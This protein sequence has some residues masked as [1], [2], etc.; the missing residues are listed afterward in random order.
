MK[1]KILSIEEQHNRMMNTPIPKL[2]LSLALPTTISQLITVIYNTADTYF[3]S[4]IGTSAAAAT[5]VVFSLMSIIQALGFGVA[6]G[7][8]SIISRKLGAKENDKANICA[9]SAFSIAVIIGLIIMIIGLLTIKK[10]M[11]LLG[12]TETILPYACDYAKY[13]LISA[14]IMC[15]SFVLNNLLRA[16]GEAVLSMWGLCTGGILNMILDPLLIFGLNMGIAGAAIATALSQCVSFVI[17]LSPFLKGKSIVKLDLRLSSRK[18][19]MYYIIIKNGFPTICRQGMASVASA[20]MNI[21]AGAYGDAVLAAITISNKV[22]LLMRNMVIGIGQGMQPVVG[23]NYGAGNKTR[24]KKAFVFT[25]IIGTLVCTIGTVIIAI[26]AQD[27][28]A[29]FR[30]DPQVIEIGTK[31]LHYGCIVMPVLA[32][33]TYVNQMFQFLGFST[34]AIFLALCRQGIFF[35]PLLMILPPILGIVGIE[36][37]QAA[38]DL[39][40]F[41]ISIPF[42]I[43]FF[44]KQLSEKKQSV[45]IFDNAK[46]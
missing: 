1:Q 28:M 11:L 12:A 25:C 19:K 10:L 33:S 37:T 42:I 35:I 22:Y 20:M 16:Q 24:V 2:V 41:V 27:I 6:T 36:I 18:P 38:A 32:F 30:D 31:M 17:L 14:P 3:V 8:N 5:G 40:T 34:Q 23:Y 9:A 13:I 45:D 15:A 26:G 4:H 7:A 44:K 43:I 29:W 39:I 21:Y 46:S